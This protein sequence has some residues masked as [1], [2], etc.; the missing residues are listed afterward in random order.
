M[1]AADAAA[2]GGKEAPPPPAPACDYCSGLPAVVYCP[3]DSARLCLPCDRHVHGANTVSTRHAR[4]PLCAG[5][6]AA[7]ATTSRR[8]GGF[9]CANCRFEE[10]ENEK[11]RERHRD[12]GDAQPL[13]H[14]RGVVEGYAGCPSVA[15]LAAI[16]GVAGYDDKSAAAAAGEGG[17]WPAWEELQVLRLEDVIIPTTSCHGLQ[18]LLTPP[19]SAKVQCWMCCC[20]WPARTATVHC[21]PK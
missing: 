16:L 13:H 1:S 4:A 14:D 9:R 19:S 20:W 2:A 3:A 12:G 7:A 15:E 21:R 10:E 6:R 17:W 8:G 18:P 5:C 11:E